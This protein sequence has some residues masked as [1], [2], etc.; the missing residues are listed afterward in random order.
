MLAVA[1]IGI[2]AGCGLLFPSAAAEKSASQ[3][4]DLAANVTVAAQPAR[5]LLVTREENQSHSR[6]LAVWLRIENTANEA[7]TF[8]PDEVTLTFADGSA[9]YTLDRERA[10]VLIERLNVAPTDEAAADYPDMWTQTRQLGLKQQLSDA[11]L[12]ERSL[13]AEAV[14]GYIL[15]DTRQPAAPLD[16]AVLHVLLSRSDGTPLRQ[17]YHFVSAAPPAGATAGQ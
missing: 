1:L 14:E 12:T 2:L 9:G 3:P 7:L 4:N 8:N 16:G 17:L 6:L 13:G 15:F 10:N 5:R 11:L